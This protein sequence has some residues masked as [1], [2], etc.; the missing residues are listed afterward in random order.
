M[1][2]TIRKLFLNEDFDGC[3][4]EYYPHITKM[5][6]TGGMIKDEKNI[7]LN[8]S[9]YQV[10]EEEYTEYVFHDMKKIMYETGER[11]YTITQQKFCCVEDG[12]YVVSKTECIDPNKFP[13]LNKYYDICHK[14]IKT[15]SNKY[16]SISVIS[17]NNK[18]HLKMS[19]NII[20]DEHHQHGVI[21]CLKEAISLQQQS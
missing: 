14:K 19:F 15:F 12:L 17:E 11:E 7:N 6:E 16:I 10:K 21:R 2:E 3:V 18:I 20:S 5:Y 1:E 9:K 8:F 4:V 13:V